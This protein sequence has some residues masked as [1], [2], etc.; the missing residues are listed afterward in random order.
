[1]NRV[2][3]SAIWGSGL[4]RYLLLAAVFIVAVSFFS[5]SSAG[6]MPNSLYSKFLNNGQLLNQSPDPDMSALYLNNKVRS[7][8]SFYGAVNPSQNRVSLQAGFKHL[9]K[10]EKSSKV[11]T[12]TLL[13]YHTSA[14]K[15]KNANYDV[16]WNRGGLL[17]SVCLFEVSAANRGQEARELKVLINGKEV[18]SEPADSGNATRTCNRFGNT[19]FSGDG[20]GTPESVDIVDNDGKARTLYKTKIEF[21]LNGPAFNGDGQNQVQFQVRSSDGSAIFSQ[22]AKSSATDF[23][24]VESFGPNARNTDAEYGIAVAVPFGRP[25]TQI[26]N[27]SANLRAYDVDAGIFGPSYIQIL[28]KERNNGNA[29]WEPL[30][31]N[32]Y[33]N[34][35]SNATGDIDNQV[36]WQRPALGQ[37]W[38][39]IQEDSGKYVDINIKNFS[40]DKKYLMIFDNPFINSINAPTGNVLSYS[41]PGESLYGQVNCS[42]SYTLEPAA[43]VNPNVST[44]GSTVNATATISGSAPGS[45]RWKQTMVAVGPNQDA[46]VNAPGG[47]SADVCSQISEKIDCE[48]FMVSSGSGRIF[49]KEDSPY[50]RSKNFQIPDGAEI[51]S[52]F[53][54]ITSVQKPTS[55]SG[56]DDWG[57]SD[58]AC[59]VI[60]KSPTVQ[61]WDHDIRTNGKIVTSENQYKNGWYGSWDEYGV[62]S[63]F[64][65]S[66]VASNAAYNTNNGL[67][68]RTGLNEVG[69]ANY[70]NASGSCDGEITSG[71]FGLT[72]T[73]QAAVEYITARATL[74]AGNTASF[75]GNYDKDT[76]NSRLITRTNGTVTITDDIENDSSSSAAQ[77]VIIATDIVI[78]PGVRNVDAWLIALPDDEGNGGRITTCNRGG[79][80]NFSIEGSKARL[81]NTTCDDSLRVNGL[82]YAKE[83]YLLRTAESNPSE[84]SMSRPAETFTLPPGALLWLYNDGGQSGRLNALT[85]TVIELPPRF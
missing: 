2:T 16:R 24:V 5:A 60:G 22:S 39:L 28:S 35:T 54:F 82:V 1:M 3:Y 9:L 65:N 66:R 47:S 41:L 7:G 62:M 38:K 57:H 30:T 32:E 52:R 29:D 11:R 25:C 72:N 8:Y 21:K 17:S 63:Q 40:H 13:S 10:N 37:R 78:R 83:L 61:V 19:T 73:S 71:C 68:S 79:A 75:E 49:T 14:N 6:A 76:S 85:R 46:P 20:S 74:T 67:A 53:C 69:F 84:D 58:P 27:Q 44:A 70:N 4:G 34:P 31:F 64:A 15:A 42:N 56:D 50:S 36:V 81:T 33:N 23:G 59:V 77:R 55:S 12:I 51:G 43:S 45:H 26:S 18:F 48:D 80:N